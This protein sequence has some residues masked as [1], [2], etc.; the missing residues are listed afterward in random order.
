M[1]IKSKSYL[2]IYTKYYLLMPFLI[3]IINMQRVLKCLVETKMQY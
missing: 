3:M 1:N 2:A